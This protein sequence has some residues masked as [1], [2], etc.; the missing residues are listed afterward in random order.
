MRHPYA[1]VPSSRPPS[2]FSMPSHPESQPHPNRRPPTLLYPIPA[3]PATL[4]L[5]G[6]LKESKTTPGH[7]V[8]HTSRVTLLVSG[9]EE[10]AAIPTYS[11]GDTIEGILA[12]AR[13]TGLLALEV[14]VVGT[15]MLEEFGGAGTVI[16][17]VVEETVYEWVPSRNGP[18]PARAAF[19]YTLPTSFLD[20]ASGNHYPLPPTYSARLDGFPGFSAD[21]AYAIVVTL[22]LQRGAS[23]LWRGVSN[24]K[25]PFRYVHRT[26]PVLVGPFPCLAQ[27][28]DDRPQTLFTFRMSP[29]RAGARGITVRVY[30]PASQVC[31]VQEPIPFHVSL[32][33]DE[34]ALDAFTQHRPLPGSFLSMSASTLS[35]N[36]SRESVASVIAPYRKTSRRCPLRVRVQRTTADKSHLYSVR[37]IGQGVV[38]SARRTCDAVVWTGAVLDSIVL[39]IE[40]PRSMSDAYVALDKM[41]PLRLT[42]DSPSYQAAIPVCP[43]R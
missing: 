39:S 1:V 29:R 21:I 23:T 14:K 15:I 4:P 6:P 2:L 3:L 10:G 8:K 27:K 9:Q 28:T 12:V 32:L 38:H 31:S 36:A 37:W 24:M 40:P 22:T 20:R 18:F 17:K 13:D 30:L 11:T 16:V 35:V 41:I 43:L 7:Y 25:V 42:S 34:R 33:G 26:R 19:R 5:G